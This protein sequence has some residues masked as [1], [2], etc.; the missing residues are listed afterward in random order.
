[1]EII[2]N[3][4]PDESLS[5]ENGIKTYEALVLKSLFLAWIPV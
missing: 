2:Q 1:M 5:S 4:K 3:C